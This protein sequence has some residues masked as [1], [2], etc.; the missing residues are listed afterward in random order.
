MKKLLLILPEIFFMGC[1]I[2]WAQ[3]NYFTAGAINY[4]A[5]L[6]CWLMFLQIVYKNR[7]L[8]VVYGATLALASVFMIVATV[9]EFGR[10]DAFTIEA[11]QLL[12]YGGG[13]FGIGA[14][15]AGGMIYRS[16]VAKDDYDESVLTVTY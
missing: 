13:L 12:S 5:L 15:M 9:S 8:G 7:V 14:L 4:I 10:S 6:I 1:G 11:V 16:L 3:E 2:Y